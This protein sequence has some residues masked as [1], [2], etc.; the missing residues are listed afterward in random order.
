MIS[1]GCEDVKKSEVWCAT[2]SITE[3]DTTLE[4]RVVAVQNCKHRVI[5]WPRNSTSRYI[6]GEFKTYVHK[7]ACI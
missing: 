2:D 4:N 5:L 7:K 3:W 6:R 1:W